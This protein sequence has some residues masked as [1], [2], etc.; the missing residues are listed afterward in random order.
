MALDPRTPV[1]IGTGQFVNRTKSFDEAIEPVEMMVKAIEAAAANA[2]LKSVPKADAIN[3]VSLLSWKYVNPAWFVAQLL[4]QEPPHLG[5][6]G[7]GGNTPQTL[8]NAAAR[9]ILANQFDVVILTGAEASRSRSKARAAGITPDWRKPTDA[10]PQPVQVT[11]EL[12]MVSPYE[13]SRGITMPVQIYPLFET[14]LRAANNRTPEQ[15]MQISSEL[16]SRFSEVAERN[17]FAWSQQ[18]LS[19]EEV[20]TAGPQNRMIGL[21][22]PKYMNSNNDVDMAAA[23]IMC[24]L[25]KAELLGVPKDHM[26]FVHSGTDCHEHKFVSDRWSFDRTP[27][28]EIGGKL[29]LNLAHSNIDDI[30]FIDLYS[31]FPVAVQLG[32]QSLGLKLD[33]DLTLTGGLPFAGGPWNNYVMHAISTMTNVLREHPDER[34]LIWA[35][36]GFTTKH[37]FGVYAAKPSR[38]VFKY[39]DPQDEIDKLPMREVAHEREAE[40]EAIVEAYTVMHDRTGNPEFALASCLLPNGKRAWGTSTDTFI[41]KAM[42]EGEWVGRMARLAADGTISFT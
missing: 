20:R 8:V 12:D 3:V 42:C 28:V 13:V 16:W 1:I 37:A 39:A 9:E 30:A 5:Y 31:C 41:T 29:A 14:A 26:I 7:T 18:A 10:T 11:D 23:V 38:D 17:P 36:G 34:G 32:A 33:R 22:Y 4:K 25:E 24:S 15:Q 19:P 6:S 40:G 35:N 21:P 2:S 27:A